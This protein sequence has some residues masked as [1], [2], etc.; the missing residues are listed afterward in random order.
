MDFRKMDKSSMNALPRRLQ[1]VVRRDCSL[2]ADMCR[3]LTEFSAELNF[4]V[5][6]VDVDAD[7]QLLAKYHTLVPVLLFD[8]HQICHYSLDLV[9]LRAALATG[10]HTTVPSGEGTHA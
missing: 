6:E 5:E 4:T 2:C 9:A 10:S 1:A 3:T 8:G 7:A